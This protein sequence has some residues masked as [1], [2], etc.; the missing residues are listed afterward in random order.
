MYRDSKG[1]A[2][3]SRCCGCRGVW[4]DG[5]SLAQCKS[6]PSKANSEVKPP[7]HWTAKQLGEGV[8]RLERNEG[9]S[10]FH[11]LVEGVIL[12]FAA[13]ML[14]V[15]PQ[16]ERFAALL[17]FGFALLFTPIGAW[18]HSARAFEVQKDKLVAYMQAGPLRWSRTWTGPAVLTW[19][20]YPRYHYRLSSYG[21]LYVVQGPTFSRLMRGTQWATVT[22]LGA[23]LSQATGWELK[24]QQ[25]SKAD[26]F[27]SGH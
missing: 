9:E 3:A 8:L 25:T 21:Y 11:G 5:E 2:H 12:A 7:G 24:C 13:C 23:L 10:F 15:S 26:K 22:A 14:W 19:Y 18:A 20:H 17:V 27:W 6:E 16:E 1:P 4:L